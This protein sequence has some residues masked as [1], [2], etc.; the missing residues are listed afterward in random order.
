[1][2]NCLIKRH[3][4][5]EDLMH[6]IVDSYNLCIFIANCPKIERPRTELTTNQSTS[7]E[8]PFD[9]STMLPV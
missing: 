2:P 1:M 7:G 6:L 9:N 5:F 8:K 4:I 3:N